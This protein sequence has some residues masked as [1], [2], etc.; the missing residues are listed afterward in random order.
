[1][2]VLF[3]AYEL[4]DEHP[5]LDDELHNPDYELQKLDD[6]DPASSNFSR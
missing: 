6:E 2:H 4:D 3:I 5:K 1:M